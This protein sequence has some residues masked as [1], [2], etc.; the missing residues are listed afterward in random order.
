MPMRKEYRPFNVEQ[1]KA[2]APIG[3]SDTKCEFKIYE[4]FDDYCIGAI[5]RIGDNSKWYAQALDFETG[6]LVML[7]LFHLQDK[8]VY[9]GDTLYDANGAA[10]QVELSHTQSMIDGCTWEV[11]RGKVETRMTDDDITD[12]ENSAF[13]SIDGIRGMLNTAIA[14]AIE[15]GDVVAMDEVTKILEVASSLYIECFN[16]TRRGVTYE[17]IMAAYKESK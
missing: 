9:M 8:P 2:G 10:F 3:Y 7:P 1:A 13:T 15:D 5:K 14:R 16:G 4:Y 17:E 6:S 12:L 11:P